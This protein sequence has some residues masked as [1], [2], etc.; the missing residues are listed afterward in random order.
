LKKHSGQSGLR[1]LEALH[2]ERRLI[3]VKNGRDYVMNPKDT[4]GNVGLPCT[5]LG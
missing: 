5:A 2:H 1:V 4:L 3:E